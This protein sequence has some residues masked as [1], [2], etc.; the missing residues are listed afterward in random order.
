M[1]TSSERDN[2][3]QLEV[4]FST[5][6]IYDVYR[7]QPKYPVLSACS[8]PGISTVRTP[9]V[10]PPYWMEMQMCHFGSTARTYPSCDLAMSSSKHTQAPVQVPTKSRALIPSKHG[11][12]TEPPSPSGKK[13]VI[14][15]ESGELPDFARRGFEANPVIRNIRR[16]KLSN[17]QDKILQSNNVKN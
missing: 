8:A 1:G 2:I 7:R 5:R 16:E 4:N 13:A 14:S 9:L 3:T 15:A 6:V 12:D 17:I 10:K 11:L